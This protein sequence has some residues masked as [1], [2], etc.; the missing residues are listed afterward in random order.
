MISSAY[1]GKWSGH[2][3]E[4]VV[5]AAIMMERVRAAVINLRQGTMAVV[6]NGNGIRA[7][8]I[9]QTEL[10]RL[11]LYASVD[12]CIERSVLANMIVGDAVERELLDVG[13]KSADLTGT[14]IP[15]PERLKLPHNRNRYSINTPRRIERDLWRA[16]L[17]WFHGIHNSLQRSMGQPTV[18][19]GFILSA[20]ILQVGR[21]A[22]GYWTTD[23]HDAA[24][25]LAESLD[26]SAEWNKPADYLGNLNAY[27]SVDR[28]RTDTIGSDL[29]VRFGLV[30]AIDDMVSKVGW[31]RGREPLFAKCD[32]TPLNEGLDIHHPSMYWGNPIDDFLMRMVIGDDAEMMSTFV[33]SHMASLLLKRLL[34]PDNINRMSGHLTAT[35]NASIARS[36]PVGVFFGG[37]K[38]TDT[39][40]R[41]KDRAEFGRVTMS[42]SASLWVGFSADTQSFSV[43][44]VDSG[45]DAWHDDGRHN[46]IEIAFHRS[47][48]YPESVGYEIPMAYDVTKIAEEFRKYR[49]TG[50]TPYGVIEAV[51]RWSTVGDTDVIE[52]T[53]S[54]L[55]D[56]I[57]ELGNPSALG[58][59]GPVGMLND[60]WLH[61]FSCHAEYYADYPKADGTGQ[62]YPCNLAIKDGYADRLSAFAVA[63]HVLDDVDADENA[64]WGLVASATSSKLAEGEQ[65]SRY[66]EAMTDCLN[67]IQSN[68]A[69]VLARAAVRVKGR[70]LTAK[71]DMEN[72]INRELRPWYAIEN[73]LNNSFRG[74]A[75]QPTYG[76][77]KFSFVHD[78]DSLEWDGELYGMNEY[79]EYDV[80]PSEPPPS[81]LSAYL[82]KVWAIGKCTARAETGGFGEARDFDFKVSVPIWLGACDWHWQA[83]GNMV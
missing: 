65:T 58:F 45:A 77:F 74:S 72:F 2:F 36:C 7:P 73:D 44:V 9:R 61:E 11:A 53:P 42:R 68:A 47:G 10:S 82:E 37:D 49:A 19:N 64:E 32:D 22:D 48:E 4:A 29:V 57:N 66:E 43:E 14:A 1:S 40:G 51:G 83:I 13:P 50:S 34:P 20:P 69:A 39:S 78:G 80:I 71:V 70:V 6:E 52:L 62:L 12:G 33:S 41:E 27:P 17:G 15:L 76:G 31:D 60:S 35:M 8:S 67:K 81:H 23:G 30:D 56:V 25:L 26:G 5:N 21:I 18:R 38:Y 79:Q 24:H 59:L 16:A 63:R 54:E 28:L 46:E 75:F 55:M 3:G